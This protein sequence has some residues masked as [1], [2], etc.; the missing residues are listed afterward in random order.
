MKDRHCFLYT[1]CLPGRRLVDHRHTSTAEESSISKAAKVATK[2]K[3]LKLKQPSSSIVSLTLS[4]SHFLTLSPP[5]T[6]TTEN[7]KV[8]TKRK[9]TAAPEVT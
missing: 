2:K 9:E 5:T 8:S 4:I 7:K 6:K 1:Q 3:K